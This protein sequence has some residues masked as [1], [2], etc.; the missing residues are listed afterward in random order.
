MGWGASYTLFS[1]AVVRPKK[2]KQR[3]LTPDEQVQ[4]NESVCHECNFSHSRGM[5]YVTRYF[6]YYST[7]CMLLSH[8]LT[9]RWEYTKSFAW[10]IYRGQAQMHL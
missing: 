1:S 9:I 2:K 10:L 5:H 7:D 3:E 4:V 6:C 8:V